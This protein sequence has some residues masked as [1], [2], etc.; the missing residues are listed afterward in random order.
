ML[1]LLDLQRHVLRFAFVELSHLSLTLALDLVLA[2]HLQLGLHRPTN[3]LLL[4]LAENLGICGT[5]LLLLETGL[6][7][8][9]LTLQLHYPLVLM[10][11]L[12]L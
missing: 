1:G 5:Q 11:S 4:L 7:L 6:T 10:N 9:D 2:R 8:V 3:F 12:L